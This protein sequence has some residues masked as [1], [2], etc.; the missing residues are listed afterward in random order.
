[1]KS[2]GLVCAACLISVVIAAVLSSEH[3]SEQLVHPLHAAGSNAQYLPLI[4]KPRPRLLAFVSDRDG[5]DTNSEIYVMNPDGSGQTN[6]TKHPAADGD[7]QWSPDGTKIAFVSYR[8]NTGVQGAIYVVKADGSGVVGL[9][10]LQNDRPRWSPDGSKIAFVSRRDGNHEIYVMNADGTNQ[11]R[12]TNNTWIDDDP[13]WS[14]DGTKI[15]FFA[16]S[17]QGRVIKVMNADGSDQKQLV[18]DIV[19]GA[20]Q[21]SPDGTKIG[22]PSYRN[23][24]GSDVFEI[25]IVNAD[26]SGLKDLTQNAVYKAR[27]T[28]SPDS[29]RLAFEG[30]DASGDIYAVNSDGSGLINLTNN[31]LSNDGPR[32]SPDGRQIA[33]ISVRDGL[34]EIYVMNADGTNQTRLTVN[35][36]IDNNPVWSP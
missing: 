25:T 18:G 2:R 1:M 19:N 33:F 17:S 6:L 34:Y 28:W 10:G 5:Q 29:Q 24:A 7:P 3:L 31:G 16:S 12:L 26:G 8:E 15:A 35:T 14:P 13:A 21:W 22:F 4:A 20:P 9:T 27:L 23:V 36:A 30:G 32:W 11:R